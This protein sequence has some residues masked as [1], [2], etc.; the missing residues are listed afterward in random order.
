VKALTAHRRAETSIF[1]RD[2]PGW[3]QLLPSTRFFGPLPQEHRSTPLSGPHRHGDTPAGEA[4]PPTGTIGMPYPEVLPF[5][6]ALPFA[7]I[8]MLFAGLKTG[9]G[10][11]FVLPVTPVLPARACS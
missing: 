8:A 1:G 10:I 9:T 7:A 4:D 6:P 2:Y 11:A 3:R 5:L